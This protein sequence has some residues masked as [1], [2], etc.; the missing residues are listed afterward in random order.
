M[1]MSEHA[2]LPLEACLDA[3]AMQPLLQGLLAATSDAGRTIGAVR[4][5][6]VRRNTS[7]RR[8]PNPI[9]LCY[10]VDLLGGPGR[11][12]AMRQFYGKAFRDGE[13]AQAAVGSAALHL[14]AV[15]MLLWRWPTDPGLPQLPALIDPAQTVRFWGAPA[16]EVT[17]VRYVAEWRATL[18]YTRLCGGLPAENLYA[19]TFSDDRGAEIHRRFLY[20]WDL[21]QNDPDAPTV[22]E[23]LAYDPVTRALWQPHAGGTPLSQILIDGVHPESLAGR[24]AYAWALVHTA[25]LHLAGPVPRDRAHW[26]AEVRRRRNKISRALPDLAERAGEVADAI[27][28]ASTL[29]PEPPAAVIHGDCHP[30]QMWVDGQRVVL[31]DFDEFALGDPMEDLAEFVTKLG[32]LGID[33]RFATTMLADYAQLAPDHFNLRRLQWHMAVQQLLQASRAFIFQVPDWAAEM[34]R[35]LHRARSLAESCTKGCAP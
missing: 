15:D 22:A 12:P 10:E 2:R 20:F 1:N 35:R 16:D 19:K 30:D 28:H 7:V 34:D 33:A 31:F 23:P 27:E 32:P 11:P 18:R 6:K 9:T 4:V 14:P 8:N 13:S 17:P 29:L 26:L 21:A 24:V 25:P 5:T 3:Q